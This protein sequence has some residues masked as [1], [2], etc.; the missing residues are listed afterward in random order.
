MNNVKVGDLVRVL[1]GAWE[2]IRGNVAAGEIAEVVHIYDNG[3]VLELETQ[4]KDVITVTHSEIVLFAK[5]KEL[6]DTR[7]S[8]IKK[9]AAELGDLLA[10]KNRDYGSSFTQQ[11]E[12]YGLMSALIRMDD[13]MRR[14]ETLQ[15]G[16]QAKVDESISD[17]LLDLA[18]Y[19]LLAYLETKT[20]RN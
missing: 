6:A 2:V 12:K 14:L 19:A 10:R 5:E 16:Q 3:D 20:R 8:E 1:P 11:Y 4:G 15:G 13:K 7:E 18:G 9:A 17:T